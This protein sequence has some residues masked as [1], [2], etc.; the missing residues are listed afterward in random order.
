MRLHS[1]LLPVFVAC[2]GVWGETLS[3]TGAAPETDSLTAAPTSLADNVVV[4]LPGPTVKHAPAAPAP[5]PQPV[6]PVRQKPVLPSA[7]EKESALYLQ[8]LI[9]TFR[10]ADAKPLLGDPIGQRASTDE[11]QSVDGQIYAFADPTGRYKELELDFERDS[12]L[13]R[14]VIVYPAKMT[15]DECR[16]LWGGEVSSEQAGKGRKFY[17]YTNRNLDVLVDAGGKVVSL[18]LY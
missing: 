13:L 18:G 14:T 1:A 5:V 3:I 6:V 7:F 16:H 2:A 15:W 11:D 12:G 17:S 10:I 8:K 4:S 9:G